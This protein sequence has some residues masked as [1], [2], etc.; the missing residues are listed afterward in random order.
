M[1]SRRTGLSQE[2]SATKADMS[3]RSG[4]RIEKRGTDRPSQSRHWR[5]RQ[6]PLAAVW[7]SELVT[8]LERDSKL[9]GL[10]LL[11]YLED[12]HPAIKG[13]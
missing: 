3:V 8:L 9:T 1:Q 11:E 5:T 2:A 13:V 7:E 12:H 6:D 10:T 4:R